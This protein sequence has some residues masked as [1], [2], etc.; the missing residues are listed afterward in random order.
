MI[1]S[2]GIESIWR[3]HERLSAAIRAGVVA[4]GLRLFSESPSHAVTTAWL[5][6]EIPWSQLNGKL[7]EEYGITVAGGQGDYAGKIFRISHL[8]YYDEFDAV[9]VI[10]GLE[11]ALADCG[12]KVEPGMGLTAVQRSLRG[13]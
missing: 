1:R 10:A 9:S 5:P 8:G 7:K 13:R 2:E 3:R 4:M 12:W 6:D 11:R